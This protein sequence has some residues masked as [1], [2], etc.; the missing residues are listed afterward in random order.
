MAHT[1]INGPIPDNVVVC[2]NSENIAFI[3]SGIISDTDTVYSIAQVNCISSDAAVVLTDDT[4]KE[5][6]GCVT[7]EQMLSMDLSVDIS[8]SG[9]TID[10]MST[11]CGDCD[12]QAPSVVSEE[13]LVDYSYDQQ[14]TTPGCVP[15]LVELPN[16][17]VIQVMGEAAPSDTASLQDIHVPEVV[18]AE[19]VVTTALPRRRKQAFPTVVR[20]GLGSPRVELVSPSSASDGSAGIWSPSML[21]VDGSVLSTTTC[22]E[23]ASEAELSTSQESFVALMPHSASGVL[24]TESGIIMPMSTQDASIREI[25][26]R[27]RDRLKKRELRQNPAFKEREK[28]K[29]RSRMR[30]RRCDPEYREVERQK[31]RCR[32]R[33]SRQR[34]FRQRQLERERDKTYKRQRRNDTVSVTLVESEGKEESYVFDIGDTESIGLD[35]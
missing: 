26:K 22:F 4:Q 21:Q 19:T 15:I 7:V 18:A 23:E 8:S 16:G 20:S 11:S 12:Q 33:A 10:I 14:V 25:T 31:D 32:R 34:N 13:Q 1:T 27:E 28:I 9:S 17:Q 6:S 5:D 2:T 30:S 3:D 29:A 24:V 35:E